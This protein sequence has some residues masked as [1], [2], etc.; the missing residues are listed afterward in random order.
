MSPD[1]NVLHVEDDFA[2]A[3]LL[4][5]ALRDA[6]AYAFK[7]EVVRTLHDAG[8]KLR[9]RGYDLIIADLRLPDSADPN[10]TVGL[11][12]KH[13]G[14]APILVL[15]GSVGIDADRIGTDIP[16][17]DKNLYFDG[18]ATKRSVELL[19]RVLEA[20]SRDRD[21]VMI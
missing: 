3:M 10:E 4:Q 17:L 5:Q 15:S 7:F 13:A 11:L 20:A 18:R 14:E 16:L 2:D 19:S 1:L 6:G 21:A 12:Q 8:F 9:R